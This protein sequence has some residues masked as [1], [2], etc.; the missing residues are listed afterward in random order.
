MSQPTIKSS[1]LAV[2]QYLSKSVA[3]ATNVTLTAVE[4]QNGVIALTGALTGNIDVIV[5]TAAKAYTM[6]NNTTGAF[7]LRVKTAAGTGYFLQQGMSTDLVC[8]GTNVIRTDT[9]VN[10]FDGQYGWQDLRGNFIG[11]RLG[12]GA[13]APS[14]TN[15]VGGIYGYTFGATGS[16]E[17]WVT[18]HIPHDYV[19]GT[20]IYI[21]MHWAPTTTNTGVVRWGIEYS[22]AKGYSQ[23]VFPATTTTF[24]E[25]AGS[26]TVLQHQIIETT[27]GNA[28]PSTNLEPDSLILVRAYRDGSHVNDTYTAGAFG[29]EVD[30]H[31]QSTLDRTT[32]NKNY[33]FS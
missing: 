31:Y 17:I 23:G 21:H 5:P 26:G 14:W 7:T 2:D 25:Q 24:L 27:L 3:G 15:V 12:T 18:F 19:P 1:A 4:A 20:V 16:D 22:V 6:S 29:F 28:I 30:L 10:S 33:P 13:N 8:D 9:V 32:K 11:S